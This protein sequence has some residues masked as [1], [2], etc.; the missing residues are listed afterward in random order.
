MPRV[1]LYRAF[2]HTIHIDLSDAVAVPGLIELTFRLDVNLFD[3]LNLSI[4]L[5]DLMSLVFFHLGH[6]A[7]TYLL[8]LLFLLFGALFFFLDFHTDRFY[9]F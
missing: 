5:L 4:L 2:G 1:V 7:Y 9:T 8:Y 6:E 3:F